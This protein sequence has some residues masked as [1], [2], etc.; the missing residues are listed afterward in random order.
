MR[1]FLV[2]CWQRT[3]NLSLFFQQSTDPHEIASGRIATWIYIVLLVTLLGIFN[4]YYS[5][6]DVSQTISI[7]TPSFHTYQSLVQRYPGLACPCQ[8]IGPLYN[9]FLE[10]APVYHQVQF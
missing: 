7:K 2:Q 10:L 4:V 6:S 9:Q 8:N 1:T 5:V 3:K